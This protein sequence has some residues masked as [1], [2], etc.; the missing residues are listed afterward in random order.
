MKHTQSFIFAL[1]RTVLLGFIAA[2]VL[3]P[4][5]LAIVHSLMTER[6]IL[7]NYGTLGKTNTSMFVNLKLIP[8]KV[9]FEQYYRVLIATPAFLQMFWNSVGLVV[10][11]IVG[12]VIAATLASFAFARLR[13]PGRDAL[14]FVYLITMMMPFQVTLVPNY[15]MVDRL[16]LM[17]TREAIILPGI[18]S[19]FGVFLLRQFMLHIHS[20]YMEAAKIDGAGY[21][22][23]FASI[24]LPMVKPGIAALVILL[25]VDYWNMVEQPLIFL[26]D[27]VLQPLSVFLS[28]IQQDMLGISFA[29]SVVYMIPIVLLFLSAEHY[30]IEG[31]QLS[32]VKG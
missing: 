21:G 25:F 7:A 2:A 15:M 24:V 27:A 26:Q 23:I 12:Q 17:N 5:L 8:D 11:I 9:S 31:I 16:G 13:F 4:V 3:S 30:L 28:V 22:R 19:A 14:F 29:A 32:G 20:A 6:E 10:P 18:F 1:I